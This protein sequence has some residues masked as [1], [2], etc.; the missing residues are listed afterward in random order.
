MT[1]KISLTYSPE[2][3]AILSFRTFDKNEARAIYQNLKDD[4]VAATFK[5][6]RP[7]RSLDANAYA[8][9]LINKLSEVT[10]LPTT[11]I[12]RESIR[13]I[14]GSADVLCML[15]RSADE[16]IERWCSKGLGWQAEK[17][18][19]KIDGCVNVM[20]FAGS[21]TFD[22]RQMSQLIDTLVQ[23]CKEMGIETLP[24]D[25]INGLLEK[26]DG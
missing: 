4:N 21:S 8:W 11:T 12:Y 15:E 20:A 10:A 6:Y 17:M 2:G 5:K 18:P 24:P 19:S 13:N 25:K 9:V 14:G 3:E 26:W 7:S 1:G 22:T 23:D 16:F